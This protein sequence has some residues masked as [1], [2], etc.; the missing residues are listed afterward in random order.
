LAGFLAIFIAA[1]SVR[2]A[3]A[4]DDFAGLIADLSSS[5]FATRQQ[6]TAALAEAGPTAF[7]PLQTAAASTDVEVRRRALSILF[8]HSLSGRI[9]HRALAQDALQRV[10]N[11]SPPAPAAAARETL[12][13]VHEVV[14]GNAVAELT[15]LGATIMPVQT[16]DPLVFN[17]QIRQTWSGG[18]AGLALLEHLPEVPWLSLENSP[19]S[20]AGL[21]HVAK[22]GQA[23]YGLSKL[24]LG[25]SR[26]TGSGLALLA[27]LES[28]QYLSLKQLPIDNERL[29]K[30]PDFPQLQ[31]LGLDGTRVGDDGL[32]TLARYPQL[33]V[34]WLD[35][36]PLTDA[37]LVHL[38]P[39]T[40]LRTLYLPSTNTAGPGLA[41]LR[42]LPSLTS[43]SL[44]GVKLSAGSLKH[45]AQLEQ[46]ESLGL[47]MTNVNDDQLADLAGLSRLRVL[48]LS[49]TAIGDPGIQHLKALHSL[50]MLHLTDTQVT[51]EGAAELGRAL[52]G[53]QL[54][55]GRFQ[56]SD[57]QVRPKP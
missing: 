43:L 19:I 38:L 53:C 55:L 40:R 26:I 52:P 42:A 51:S 28:L 31:Y 29:A 16:G 9:D 49:G 57:L 24:Y 21:V 14:A 12:E 8:A 5:D 46:L 54:M 23:S 44:K 4:H 41:E 37:G 17:V 50:Q 27:P 11:A 1:A 30:L 32:K 22:L 34:L 25:S 13:R 20:D 39:L 10:A 2:F 45:V 18:D 36:T 6:A 3:G 15:R 48:W 33:Q 7:G 56:L 35:N 47:D